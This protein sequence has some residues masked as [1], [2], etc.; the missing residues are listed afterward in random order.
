MLSTRIVICNN[1]RCR[2]KILFLCVLILAEIMSATLRQTRLK[3]GFS[4]SSPRV[5]IAAKRTDRLQLLTDAKELVVRSHIIQQT[6]TCLE[7]LVLQ[8]EALC[9]AQSDALKLIKAAASPNAES[10]AKNVN[11]V[12][13]K[14]KQ[15]K[16]IASVDH[17]LPQDIHDMLEP[18][19][20]LRQ[21]LERVT[22]L[23][24]QIKK[25]DC[26]IAQ[27]IPGTKSAKNLQQNQRHKARQVDSKRVL[28]V[29]SNQSA[30]VAAKHVGCRGRARAASIDDNDVGNA[31]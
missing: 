22:K 28:V 18:Q 4:L 25:Q 31:D 30:A 12:N 8:F 10:E 17:Q 21:A 6:T 20:L 2:A 9:A 27:Q 24:V 15:P 23:A 19:G 1:S 3:P 11:R 13:G 29:E 7:K 14:D 16:Q 5:L 26:T